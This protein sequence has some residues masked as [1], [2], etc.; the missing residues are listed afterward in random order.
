[1]SA[2]AD[3]ECDLVSSKADI[4][5]DNRGRRV[6]ERRNLPPGQGSSLLNDAYHFLLSASWTWITLLFAGMFLGTNLLFAF[7]LWVGHANVTTA[8]SF[9]DYFWFSVQSLATIGYG[10]LSPADT[11]S[12]TVV[13][14][15]SFLGFGFSALVTGV[16]FARFST[17]SA[18]VMFSNVA[19][20]ADYDGQRMF[21]FRCAN[22]RLTAIVEA[23]INVYLTR[24][25]T[26]ANGERQRRI[27]ELPL[28]LSVQPNFSLSWTVFHPIDEASPLHGIQPD[29]IK[30]GVANILI[31][32]Q[33]TDDRLAA[34]VHTRWTY[35]AEDI[36]FDRR[37][38]DIIKMDAD[39]TRYLD[40]APF[41]ETEPLLAKPAA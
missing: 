3:V 32:F 2:A 13:T 29:G 4:V 25:E 16:F 1:M 33:G 37:F 14:I 18:R 22:A 5:R 40:F 12:N 11:L 26:L 34:T 24:D 38:A 15:E 17:P 23:S 36:L 8:A 19:I 6:I 31:T 20:I 30:P 41:H 27:Y 10:V 7:I 35:N 9:L 39:G 28:R 21:M